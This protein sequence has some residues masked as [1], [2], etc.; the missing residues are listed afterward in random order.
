MEIHEKYVAITN[1][2]HLSKRHMYLWLYADTIIILP[3]LE[4]WPTLDRV[5]GKSNDVSTKG[6][7]R[8][9][10]WNAKRVMCKEWK[11]SAWV[12]LVVS[13]LVVVSLN[14]RT[15]AMP[16][17]QREGGGTRVWNA[18]SLGYQCGRILTGSLRNFFIH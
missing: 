11:R 1:E 17:L 13:V 16:Q 14:E 15:V 7:K 5:D 9:R 2:M 6:N 18:V 10:G 3:F 4:G 8:E 12:A